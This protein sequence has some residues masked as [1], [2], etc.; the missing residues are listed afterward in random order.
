VERLRGE[1]R[2]TARGLVVFRVPT[3]DEDLLSL[4]TTED[5]FLFAWGTDQLTHRPAVD[6]DKIRQWTARADWDQLLRLHH[7]V[8]P[9]PRGRPTYR[10]V[11]QMEGRH[12]YRRADAAEQLAR[13]LA[14]KFPASWR[15]AEENASVEVWLTIDGPTAVCG[16]RLSDR[17]MRHRT[18]KLEHRPASL[19]PTVAAAMVRL[20]GIPPG[21]TV[22]DPMCGAG[23][24]LAEYLAGGGRGKTAWGGDLDFASVRGAAVNLR[25]L[26]PALLAC[27]DARQLP[28]PPA[29]ADRILCNPP[30]GKQLAVGEDLGEFY[31]AVVAE[32]DRVLRPGGRAVFVVAVAG[33]LARACKGVGWALARQVGVRILGQDAVITV[34]NKPTG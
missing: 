5:V 9:K 18:Y 25:R 17:T 8:R 26:G 12:G 27:W 7:A 15:P 20:A 31:R 34:W 30:F 3:I 6:L 2:R 22:L 29:S 16:L 19:R 1:V 13:G 32:A 33:A 10:L 4:R 24:L 11:T 28:L 23:T 14:G 21:Q